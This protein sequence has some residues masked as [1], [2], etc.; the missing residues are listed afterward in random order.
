MTDT[1]T[2]APDRHET[3][4]W[5]VFAEVAKWSPEQVAT[6]T[7]LLGREPTADELRLRFE[8]EIVRQDGNLLTTAGL[9]WFM[10]RATS[11]NPALLDNTHARI[12]LGDSN[13]AEAVGQ[14]DLQAA[15]GS[16]HRW[17]MPMDAGYPQVNN[18]TITCR[19]T[20]AAGDA[21]FA[22]DT[23]E[24]CIDIVNAGAT[25]GAT[26]GNTMVNRKVFS[27]GKKANGA[28]WQTTVGITLA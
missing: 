2:V 13:A 1:V 28:V 21:N 10:T 11:N 22:T 23:V 8:P 7:D 26:V 12:G 15:A 16:A 24:W 17:F 27:F 25:A 3:V 4:K 14:T 9:Q 20:F 6:L 19:S 5:T 18:G